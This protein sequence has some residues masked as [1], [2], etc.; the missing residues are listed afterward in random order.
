MKQNIG[1]MDGEI[2]KYQ[3]DIQE[4]IKNTLLFH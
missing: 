4:C 2:L 3:Y 1:F